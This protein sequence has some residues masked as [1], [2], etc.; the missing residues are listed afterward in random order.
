MLP[1]LVSQG[2]CGHIGKE[3]GDG[4]ALSINIVVALGNAVL[5]GLSS[6]ADT[7]FSQIQGSGNREELGVVLQRGTLIM[8]LCCFPCCAI[9]LNAGLICRLVG[10]DEEVARVAGEY[11]TILMAGLPGYGLTLLLS[12]FIQVQSVLLPSLIIGIIINIENVALHVLFIYALELGIGGAAI[13]VVLSQ[14]TSVIIHVLFIACTGYKKDTW[15]GWN[16]LCLNGWSTF[17][18]LAVP[19]IFMLCLEIWTAEMTTFFTGLTSKTELAAYASLFIVG[20]MITGVVF[21][22][23]V[24]VSMRVGI[25]LGAGNSDQANVSSRVTIGF[26]FC[27]AVVIAVLLI[28]LKDVIPH[29]FSN[30]EAVVSMA[31]SFTPLL[32][33]FKFFE[34]YQ[35][36]CTGILRGIGFQTFGAVVNFIGSFLIGFPVALSLMLASPLRVAGAWFGTIAGAVVLCVAFS[37]RINTVDWKQESIKARK[38][39][40]IIIENTAWIVNDEAENMQLGDQTREIKDY[41]SFDT[42]AQSG[43]VSSNTPPSSAT[44]N[45]EVYSK[46]VTLVI[47]SLIFAGGLSLRLYVNV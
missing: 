2:F 11:V 1:N 28:S 9:L 38:R 8:L 23:S 7:L 40:G 31:T 44:N 29:F 15:K 30:N 43:I 6:A 45:F 41:R 24:A 22:M 39:A 32:A 16:K 37:I 18:K 12:K 3:E 4:V 19:G 46:V 14:W 20:L 35:I 27:F 42:S 33:I 47:V 34:I 36:M 5:L 13:A 26:G 21:G 17:L 10:Q 25:H